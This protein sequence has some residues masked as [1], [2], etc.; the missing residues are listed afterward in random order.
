MTKRIRILPFHAHADYAR[1]AS[2]IA[3]RFEVFLKGVREKKLKRIESLLEGLESVGDLTPEAAQELIYDKLS[4]HERICLSRFDIITPDDTKKIQRRADKIFAAR[5][6]G[7]PELKHA[8]DTE[9]GLLLLASRGLEVCGVVTPDRVDEIIS[10][11][12]EAMPWMSKVTT[13][14]MHRA[15]A[16]A[17]SGLPFHLPPLLLI[18]PPSLG[19][20]TIGPKVAEGFGL[21]FATVGVGSSGGG[22]FALAGAERGWSSA[23][24]G[25]VVRTILEQQVANPLII[26]DE[27]DKA[28]GDASTTRGR[29]LPG[30]QETLLAMIEPETARRWR[31]PYFGVDVDLRH[32]SWI[33]TANSAEGISPAL[34]SRCTG[35]RIDEISAAQVPEI[36]RALAGGR[37]SEEITDFI[38]RELAQR[39][40]FRRV[41]LRVILR[42]I[43]KAEE[44]TENAE[45]LLH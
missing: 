2:A 8:T 30:P 4:E 39:A 41:D 9:K 21:P 31:C 17:R 7:I 34:L 14:V 1:P 33:L 15:R 13:H 40:R 12:H 28:A 22:I 32:V 35:I 16:Q 38:V 19:K 43:Q 6:K 44:V 27:I 45:N 29:S 18:S 36:T 24:P 20:S 42:A 11:V 37:L 26:I 5:T 25:V 10:D 3:R 23:H